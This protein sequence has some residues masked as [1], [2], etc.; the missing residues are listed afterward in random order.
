MTLALCLERTDIWR[1]SQSAVTTDAVVP[2]G[3]DEL[4]SHLPGGGWPLGALTEIL[5]EDIADSPLWLVMPALRALRR[6]GYWQAWIKPPNIPFA[7]A[8]VESGIDLSKMLIIR[9]GRW[10][11]ILWAAEQALGSGSCNTVLFWPKKSDS[12]A[13]RRLQLAA[14]RGRT[15]GL[16]F[17]DHR[18]AGTHSTAALRLLYQPGLKTAQLSILKCRGG[19]LAEK[20]ELVRSNSTSHWTCAG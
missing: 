1:G 20:L 13:L 6:Q 9:P 3:F 12:T 4:D 16:C 18:S 2:S 10:R 5:V 15:L 14:E 19:H 8:L 17:R 11:D 7:P